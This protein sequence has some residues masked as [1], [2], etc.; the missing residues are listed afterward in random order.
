MNATTIAKAS[1][2]NKASILHDVSA[3]DMD[4]IKKVQAQS[5]SFNINDMQV[6]GEVPASSFAGQSGGRRW[7]G[8]RDLLVKIDENVKR[9]YPQHKFHVMKGPC[10]CGEVHGRAGNA[11]V[12]LK[13][14]I[15]LLV[16][17]L[18]GHHLWFTTRGDREA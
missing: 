10:G 12:H 15:I 4:D 14:A 17:V 9:Q 1:A 3:G 7:A 11:N 6:F 18:V 13:V 16:I 8:D 2:A 5:R